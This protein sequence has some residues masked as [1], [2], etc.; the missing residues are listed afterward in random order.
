L[1]RGSSF[2]DSALSFGMI[3]GGKI[4][5][6]ILGAMQVSAGGD[7][8]N[9]MIPGKMVKGMGG[10]MD[11]VHGAKRVIVLMEHIARDGSYKIVNECS[12]PYTGRGVVQRIITDI[13]V[14]DVTGEGL[15]L[16]EV[17]PGVSVDEVRDK[18][19]PGLTVD[20]VSTMV[21]PD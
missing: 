2:F 9:W 20:D 3:R 18:T 4:D 17:A 14:I 8:A 5:A 21:V 19:E 10:A 6:A 15:R 12:L 13:A 1:R 16:I 11:L 7:I